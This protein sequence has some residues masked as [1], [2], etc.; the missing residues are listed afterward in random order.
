MAAQP[1][2]SYGDVSSES[3]SETEQSVQRKERK[4]GGCDLWISASAVKKCSGLCTRPASTPAIA[5][6][7]TAWSTVEHR[8]F[9][10]GLR[11]LGKARADSLGT[12]C[13]FPS[14]TLWVGIAWLHSASH[15]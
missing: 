6:A 3:Y 9:L 10:V 8:R 12:P 15:A 4:R 14:D 5:R 11:K 13:L 7:G 2:Q 1:G